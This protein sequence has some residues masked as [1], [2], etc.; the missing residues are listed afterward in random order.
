VRGPRPSR[1]G[2][3]PPCRRG[4]LARAPGNTSPRRWGP[5]T[6]RPHA[7]GLRFAPSGP[8]TRRGLCTPA[9]CRCCA[10]AQPPH[11]GRVAGQCPT[12]HAMAGADAP[13]PGRSRA[14]PSPPVPGR[15][16]AAGRHA[17]EPTRPGGHALAP[18]RPPPESP[19]V[20]GRWR[21]QARSPRLMAASWQR[22]VSLAAAG[23]AW[24]NPNC[25]LLLGRCA[26]DLHGPPGRPPRQP[27]GWA[28]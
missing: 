7:V 11:W 17:H 15:G 14:V 9:R 18:P 27:P 13:E 3:R 19:A 22:P 4:I 1:R 25:R 5:H 12:N 2:R 8:C 28:I 20:E 23:L 10:P 6:A 26:P 16:R 21:T 24:A